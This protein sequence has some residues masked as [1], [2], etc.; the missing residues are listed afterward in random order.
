MK[1]SIEYKFKPALLRSAKTYRVHAGQ[2][3]KL[4]KGGKLQSL[5]IRDI[6]K[7][8]YVST[9]VREHRF[10]RLDLAD[11]AGRKMRISITT[12]RHASSTNDPD[13]NAF[14]QLMHCI[15]E[16]FHKQRPAQMIIIGE[17]K[18]ASW[19]MFSIG[20]L[21]VVGTVGLLILA[22]LT[23]VSEQKLMKVSLPILGLVGFGI[24]V[25]ISAS[26]WK[27]R[28]RVSPLQF[29]KRIQLQGIS[30]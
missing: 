16:Q 18:N 25:C 28:L 3:E 20:V 30:R 29:C 1:P 8:R 10:R 22:L 27:P 2:I 19:I 23:G 7:A 5:R 15:G 12:A 4:S 26:P 6:C 14:Y 13:L 11:N 17:T 9:S 24:Y 21:T